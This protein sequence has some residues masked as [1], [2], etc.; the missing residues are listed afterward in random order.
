MNELRY[1]AAVVTVS[2][3]RTEDDDVGGLR[4]V[5]ILREFG[6]EIVEKVIVTDDRDAIEAV[7]KRLCDTDVDLICTTGGTGFAPRDNT[8]EATRAVILREA[9]GLAEEM[10]RAT[11]LINPK[12]I[13]SRGVCGIRGRSL[14][15]NFPGSPKGVVE[16]FDAV[17][18]VL[19][20]ALRMLAGDTKH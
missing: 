16:C 17:E 1:R 10:R 7:L 8:P 3:T 6:A 15:L 2:D 14:I 18:H 4:L 11:A 13:L 20:H 12:S 9:P 5:E 19:P